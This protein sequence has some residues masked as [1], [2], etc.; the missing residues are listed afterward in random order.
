MNVSTKEVLS[1]ALLATILNAVLN[2]AWILIL[3]SILLLIAQGFDYISALLAAP[4]RGQVRSS[5]KGMN[6]IKKKIAMWILVFIGIMVDVAIYYS[7]IITGIKTPRVFI[8]SLSAITIIFVNELISICE[9]MNDIY[10]LPFLNKL[11]AKVSKEVE[12][13]A[14]EQVEILKIGDDS[15]E[16]QKKDKL[17]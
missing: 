10:N 16:Y 12:K 7:F 8:F 3:P 17:S 14:E 11:L 1:S 6:G 9:N 4:N 15:D 5:V 2:E 13:K